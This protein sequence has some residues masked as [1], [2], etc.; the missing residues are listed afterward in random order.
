MDSAPLVPIA[1]PSIYKNKAGAL[2]DLPERMAHCTPDTNAALFALLEAVRVRGGTLRL[3]DLFRSREMQ[4]QAHQDFA[5]GKKKAFSPPSGSSMHEAGRA[6]DIDLDA[7]AMP[8]AEFWKLAKAE[9]VEPIIAA[10]DAKASEAWHF[11]CRGSFALVREHYRAGKASNM[12]PAQ[13]MGAAAI[14]ALGIELH[15]FA[16]RLAAV[17]LQSGLIRLGADPGAIDGDPGQRTEAALAALNLPPGA[18]PASLAAVNERVAKAF[19]GEFR[20]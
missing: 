15:A 5:T 17:Q 6:F 20:A 3:S 12:K 9:G 10:P 2:T 13:A 18:G 11:E 4:D 16:G 14:A 7:I 19:P 1:F 8:L